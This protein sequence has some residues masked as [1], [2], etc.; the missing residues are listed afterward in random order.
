MVVVVGHGEGGAA[1]I[2]AG[3]VEDAGIVADAGVGVMVAGSS[4]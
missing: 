3:M 4:W 1:G 2:D